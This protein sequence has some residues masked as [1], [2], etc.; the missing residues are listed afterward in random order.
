MNYVRKSRHLIGR[1]P[2]TVRSRARLA[3]PCSSPGANAIDVVMEEPDVDREGVVAREHDDRHR[4]RVLGSMR[5]GRRRVRWRSARRPGP[6]RP[7]RSRRSPRRS[8]AIE[9][10]RDSSELHRAIDVLEQRKAGVDECLD[11]CLECADADVGN[12]VERA[13]VRECPVDRRADEIVQVIEV[14]E[15]RTVR[16]AGA[17]GDFRRGGVEVTLRGSSRAVR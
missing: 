2:Q 10:A 4:R 6:G 15:D 12:A 3:R 11:P 7:G 8:K 5:R 9:W 14:A 13:G 1:R 17:V 16:D